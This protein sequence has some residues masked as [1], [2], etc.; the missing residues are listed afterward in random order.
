MDSMKHRTL[1]FAVLI[2]SGFACICSDSFAQTCENFSVPI[3]TSLQLSPPQITLHWWPDPLATSYTVN[4]R[5]FAGSDNWAQIGSGGALDSVYVDT[6]VNVGDRYEYQVFKQWKSGT[7]TYNGYGYIAAGIKAPLID[8]MG[9]VLLLIDDSVATFLT[10]EL[11]TLEQDLIHDGWTVYTQ[12]VSRNAK[13]TDVKNYVVSTQGLDQNLRTVFIFGH[14]PVPYSGDINPDGHPQHLGAWPA[15]VYYG[16][17]NGDWTDTDV[18]D[19]LGDRAQTRNKP[20]DGK[21][22]QSE[23]SNPMDLE[24]G[25]VDLWGMTDFKLS[26]VELL[27]QYL[28]K[29]HNFRVGALTAPARAF[30]SDNFGAFTGTDAAESFA[31]SAWRTYSG[32]FGLDSIHVGG[33][34]TWFT[35]LDSQV[36]LCAYGCGPGDYTDAGGIGGTTNFASTP[37]KAIF[38]MLFGSFFGDW[39]IEN[40]FLRAPLC[41]EYGLTCCW[42]GRPQWLLHPMAIGETIGWCTR[43]TQD[44]SAFY[45]PVQYNSRTYNYASDY[46]SGPQSFVGTALMGD[47]T[48]KLQYIPPI[49]SLT[50]SVSNGNWVKLQWTASPSSAVEGYYAY[51]ATNSGGPFQ[52]ISAELPNTATTYTDSNAVK[53]SDFYMVRAI[54][55]QS[56]ASASYYG[57][58]E[59]VETEAKGVTASVQSDGKQIVAS[60]NARRISTGFAIEMT[61]PRDEEVRLAVYDVTGREVAILKSG[62][63]V[64]GTSKAFWNLLTSDGS[65]A[66]SGAYFVRLL[67]P[68]KPLSAKIVLTR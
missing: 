48:L 43:L 50:N 22:D 25:R 11:S 33:G 31:S 28:N 61:A 29:D 63:L 42:A 52:R 41:S 34:S 53:D 67:G 18:N 4:R 49:Q 12:R 56:T 60:L 62:L 15:D 38:T 3:S 35:T 9:S 64:S 1:G 39:D 45:V 7:V 10:T 57:A 19:T 2:L 17:I 21:F 14:V 16:S 37:S 68:E 46:T 44:S 47:P 13:V 8:N 51:R 20:G 32:F 5:T 59:G 30:I 23:P 26:E 24:V 6:K 54:V 66:P 58:S 40:N 27:R 36:Y 55:L 65:V